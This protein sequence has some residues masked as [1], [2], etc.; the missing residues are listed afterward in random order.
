M[1]L[2]VPDLYVSADATRLRQVLLNL[3]SNAIKYNH[4]GGLVRIEAEACEAGEVLLRVSDTGRG[5]S[6]QQLQQLFEPFNR[7]GSESQGIEGTGIGLAIAKALVERMGGAVRV[8]SREGEGSLFELRL[9]STQAPLPTPPAA[10]EPLA[11]ASSPKAAPRQRTVLYIEDNPVNAL[12]I[13]ELIARRTDL[14][15]LVATDGAS[16]VSQATAQRP[17]LILLDMQL[18]DFD[19]YEVL[20]RLRLQS[21]TAAIPCIA[22]SANA[23]PE[24]IE[25]ALRAGVSDYWTKPLDF[26]A[27]MESLDALFG[28]APSEA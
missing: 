20:R 8:E 24:D 13:G 28:K 23:M 21:Q 5:M 15:L 7:L 26:K 11:P 27:F 12:I 18:P 2:N 17:D 25:R 10:P 6:P 19:G 3:L 4:H 16:G 9:R 1:E 14:V 22:L